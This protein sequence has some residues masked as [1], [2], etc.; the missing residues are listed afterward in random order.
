VGKVL[1]RCVCSA[2]REALGR[3]RGR[4]GGDIL[5]RHAHSLL[6][7]LP[8]RKM[9]CLCVFAWQQGNSKKLITNF[10]ETF[11]GIGHDPRNKI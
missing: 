4:M 7:L 6:L 2:A 5:C 10:D 8:P 1:L 3:P 11:G 9:L